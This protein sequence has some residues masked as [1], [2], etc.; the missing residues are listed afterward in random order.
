MFE[1]E[2][3]LRLRLVWTICKSQIVEY[4]SSKP[5]SARERNNSLSPRVEV[6]I[7]YIYS[8]FNEDF[9][10][11]QV[12]SFILGAGDTVMSKT[13]KNTLVEFILLKIKLHQY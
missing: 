5:C 8:T 11:H 1:K 12:L 9:S 7:Q 3:T 10:T 13:V 4:L 6:G 2:L